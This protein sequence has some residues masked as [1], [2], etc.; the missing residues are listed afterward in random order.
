MTCRFYLGNCR[1]CNK[2]EAIRDLNDLC[3][4]CENKEALKRNYRELR[5]IKK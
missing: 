4:D 1:K 5:S 3:T 2:K